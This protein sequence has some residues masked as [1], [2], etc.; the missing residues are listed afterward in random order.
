MATLTKKITLIFADSGS[1]DGSQHNKYWVG[2]L[3]DNN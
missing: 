2:E 1:I 3:Y